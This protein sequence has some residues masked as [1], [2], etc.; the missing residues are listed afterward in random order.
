MLFSPLFGIWLQANTYRHTHI[1]VTHVHIYW[2]RK[3]NLQDQCQSEFAILDWQ[4]EHCTGFLY[5]F[6]IIISSSVFRST[7]SLENTLFIFL[8]KTICHLKMWNLSLLVISLMYQIIF[9]FLLQSVYGVTED[10]QSQSPAHIPAQ[11]IRKTTKDDVR[12]QVS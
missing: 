5:V 8:L 1:S 11:P 7:L 12:K 10:S 9:N 2:D 6:S 4:E 3:K